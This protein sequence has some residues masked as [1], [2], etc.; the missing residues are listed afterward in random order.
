MS[1]NREEEGD[2]REDHDVTVI[3]TGSSGFKWFVL[4]AAIGAGL[5]IL[6]AP[7]SGERTRRDLV[8]RGRRLRDTAADAVGDATDELQRRGRR[9]KDTVEE[10]AE[11]VTGAIRRG[12]R[13][14]RSEAGD[15]RDEMERR[16][17][18]ARARAR[19]A[20]NADDEAEARPAGDDAVAT[21]D[22]EDGEELG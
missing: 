8:R 6:F 17:S 21:D 16:L 14:V 4:G 3:E 15:A 18:R 22:A 1:R 9:I 2:V 7:Q 5:G 12:S 13:R 10:V 20:V 19:A 11:E